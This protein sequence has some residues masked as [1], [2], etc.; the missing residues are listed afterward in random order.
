MREVEALRKELVK[1]GV[2][3]DEPETPA[4]GKPTQNG[5]GKLI[6]DALKGKAKG[7]SLEAIIE[8]T[9]I[10]KKKLHGII[11]GL[12]KKKEIAIIGRGVYK[13]ADK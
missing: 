3:A 1:A 4:I 5:A 12:K 10:E 11:Y 8:A 9:G 7:L 6:L 13:L 2:L